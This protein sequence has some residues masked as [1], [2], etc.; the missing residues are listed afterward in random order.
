MARKKEEIPVSKYEEL[1]KR[2][3]TLLRRWRIAKVASDKSTIK[4]KEVKDLITVLIGRSK[5][6][7]PD[8]NIIQTTFSIREDVAWAK[9]FK[10]FTDEFW[11][12][13]AD[14]PEIAEKFTYLKHKAILDNK[15]SPSQ[16]WEVREIEKE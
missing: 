1:G 16:R 11:P 14:M 12:I 6:V 9:A 2:Q 3:Q 7:M 5:V 15:A 8:N 10:A 4:L 13:I